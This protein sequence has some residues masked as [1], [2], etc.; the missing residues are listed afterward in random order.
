MTNSADIDDFEVIFN[1]HGQPVSAK[2]CPVDHVPLA[3]DEGTV[4]STDRSSF[5]D[6]P[7]A[8]ESRL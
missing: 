8:A 4:R 3:Y 7:L 5:V 6:A 1:T 2:L